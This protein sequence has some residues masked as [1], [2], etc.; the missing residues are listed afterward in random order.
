MHEQLKLSN[1]ICFRL[2]TASR[3]LTQAYR[4]FLAPLGITYPQYLVLM[5]LWEQD[6]QMVSDITHRLMLDTNTV[7][8]LLQRMER[9]GLVVRTKGNVDGRQRMVSLTKKGRQLEDKAQDIPRCMAAQWTQPDLE[10]DDIAKLTETLDKMIH[11]QNPH[12]K[13]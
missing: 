9:D 10:E 1:Q 4:P 8:P 13:E 5:V 7:T 11:H 6:N 2:Y 12:T 3:L